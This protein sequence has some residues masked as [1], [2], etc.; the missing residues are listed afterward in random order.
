M[1]DTI[2]NTNNLQWFAIVKV[3]TVSFGQHDIPHK[4]EDTVREVN[5]IFFRHKHP[6]K[7]DGER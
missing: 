4:K 1:H 5:G 6:L 2:C 3:E 7:K